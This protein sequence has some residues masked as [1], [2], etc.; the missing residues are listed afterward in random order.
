MFR[1]LDASTLQNAV[2]IAKEM[3]IDPVGA[4]MA[5]N[6]KLE[7]NKFLRGESITAEALSLVFNCIAYLTAVPQVTEPEYPAGAP[8]TLIEKINK[9]GT[10]KKKSIL[11]KNMDNLGFTKVRFVK[12]PSPHENSGSTP[13]SKTVRTHWR[14]GHWRSQPCGAGMIRRILLWIRPCIVKP[15]KEKPNALPPAGH[16]YGVSGIS[17]NEEVP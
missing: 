10:P 12:D 17:P 1:N 6:L 16:I 15:E 14:R 3:N 4:A 7:E 13:T 9:A 5:E 8:Q 11:S 2:A